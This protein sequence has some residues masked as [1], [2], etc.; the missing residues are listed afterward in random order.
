[1]RKKRQESKKYENLI[2]KHDLGKRKNKGGR[3]REG[4]ERTGRP[5]VKRTER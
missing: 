2:G 5:I 1:M 4:A 3:D